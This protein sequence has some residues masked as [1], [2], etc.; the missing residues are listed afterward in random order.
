MSESVETTVYLTL[1][2]KYG[3][4]PPHDR[5]VVGMTVSKVTKSK[6]EKAT[7]PVIKLRLS[8]PAAAFEPLAP[9]VRIEVPEAALD[10][11][12]VVIV[13]VAGAQS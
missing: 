7:G 10:F 5:P 4:Y 8:I 9:T 6:P 1:E 3:T 12:P 11:E 2:P 13:D